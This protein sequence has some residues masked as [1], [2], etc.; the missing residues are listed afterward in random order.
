MALSFGV[1]VLPDPPYQRLIELMQLAEAQ[2][3]EY[4]WTYDSHVLWQESMP[5]MALAADQTSKIK[6]GHMVTNPA[7]R[8]PT[9]LASAYAT[10]QDISNG[11]MIMGVG[12]GDSS[13][14]YVG[15]KP[16]KVAEF[17]EA[18]QM[19]KPF[20]NGKEV[21][22]NGKQLQLKWV[23]PELPEIEMHV[24]G[25]GPKALAV[26]GRQGDGVII[27]LADPDIIQWIMD[28]A[29]KA[30]EE[31]GRDPA[32]LKCIVSAPSHI[33]DDMADARDQVRWFP[34]M[35]SNH[36]Q[37]LIDRYGTD[38]SVVPKVLTDYV[39]ARKFYD[40]DEHSR[41]GAKHGEF[42][43]DEICDR[44]CVLGTPEQATAKLK[45]LES[46]GV[47]QY[48]IYLMTEGQEAVLDAYGREI[49]PQFSGVAQ[50]EPMTTSLRAVTTG[51]RPQTFA[52]RPAF[53]VTTAPDSPASWNEVASGWEK[54]RD[55]VWEASRGV[56]ERLVALLDP[57]AGRD[58]A[59]ARRRPGR[60]GLPGRGAARAGRSVALDRH[61]AGD[62][63]RGAAT[64]GGARVGERGVPGRGRAEARS[65]G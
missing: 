53:T 57:Q 21:T 61:R 29:R 40:Y 58:G 48:N 13:V 55:F 32:A 44:F 63:G 18:L 30:A 37:D 19:V 10:L 41:V 54:R 35:V 3:F 23:R 16:M 17:E 14:R 4:A 11:R 64:G 27:Q 28:T 36:V 43:T 15:R 52:H 42:V 33:S 46:I 1:T 7:I 12:R 39:E 31:A 2:G 20:M 59:R 45:E 6:L 26:A 65:R 50:R 34:A 62:A 49:M 5:V 47:D 9:V 24:A 60:H 25:Y 51:L 38:G 22:W 8:D 56:A